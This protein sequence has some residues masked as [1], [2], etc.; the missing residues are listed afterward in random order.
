MVDLDETWAG[1]AI[2][3]VDLDA[4]FAAVEQLD[5]PEWRGKPVIVGGDPAKRGVV[6]TAS[7]EARRFGV[8]SAM[9]SARAVRL[10]PNA[11]WAPAH[12]ERYSEF[13]RAVRA[14]FE[15][16]TPRVQPVSIDEA[17]LDITPGQFAHEDPIGIAI[18]IRRRVAELGITCSAGLATSK[19]VAKIASEY[20]KP[21]GLTVVKPGTEAAFLAPL[22]VGD[23][24]G[25]GPQTAARLQRLGIVTL[26]DLAE[27]DD[28]TALEILGSY[29]PSLVRRARGVDT[30]SVHENEPVKSVSNERTFASDIHDP[31]ALDAALQ[32]LATRVESRL[33][34][35]GLAGR[36]VTVKLRYGD[37]TTRTIQR[38]LPHPTTS[39]AEFLPAARELIRSV[40][41]PGV[42]V[43]LLGLGMSGFEEGIEQL[44]LLEGAEDARGIV[45]EGERERAERVARGVEAVRTRFGD[46]AV[47]L[48]RELPNVPGPEAGAGDGVNQPPDEE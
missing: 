33:R 3:H 22:P 1:P 29:G 20:R 30:R 24:S 28:T 4:F 13:S 10:C 36:T 40:W 32:R 18:R 15:S 38:T 23:M 27:I 8:H 17:F 39:T 31:A 21:D 14:I 46:D 16:E 43:R 47:R 2:L 6:S 35:K 25:I 19:T 42:G 34:A 37:F 45:S 7:Y 9:P 48:G 5:H 44:H 12:F 41:S 26:G 11:I